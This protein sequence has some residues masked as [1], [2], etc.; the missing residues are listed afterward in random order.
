VT[1][2][3]ALS[4]PAGVTLLVRRAAVDTK[5]AAPFTLTWHV[6]ADALIGLQETLEIIAQDRAGNATS[7]QRAVSVDPPTG[8]RRPSPCMRRR[9]PRPVRPSRS[10]ST[11]STI[12]A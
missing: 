7:L 3:D 8:R 2:A 4:G 12:A 5:T 1:V 11:R 10:S 9:P 6:P